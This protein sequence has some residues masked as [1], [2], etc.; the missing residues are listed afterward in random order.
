MWKAKL[1]LFAFWACFA[2]PLFAV[3]CDVVGFEG[4]DYSVCEVDATQQQIRFFLNNPETDQPL[5]S[6]GNVQNLANEDDQIL[7]FGMNGGMYHQDRRP[8]GL[9]VEDGKAQSKLI[10]SAGPGNFGL[11]PN[12]VFCVREGRADVFETLRF[13]E[14][15]PDCK[16]A[17]QSGPML[18]IDSALHPR[19]LPK[20]DS[21]HIRNG[22]GTS[23]DGSKVWFAIS[24]EPVNFHS[25]ARLF[26]DHLKTPNALFLDGSISKLFAPDLNRRDLGFPMGP[27][28][29]VVDARS[30]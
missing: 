21:L 27:I 15:A 7:L 28:I 9:Y 6:F 12:G 3:D 1:S 11:I 14:R 24:Q 4:A 18:V 2:A 20:S 23:A 26:R 16:F 30:N 22:V 8:V 10:T 25:F 19:F 13:K 17:T 29:G 5:G